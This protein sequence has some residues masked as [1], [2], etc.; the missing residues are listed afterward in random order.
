MFLL[1]K[2]LAVTPVG[3]SDQSPREETWRE[4]DQTAGRHLTDRKACQEA[5]PQE[6]QPAAGAVTSPEATPTA[7]PAHCGSG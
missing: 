2:L 3:K 6:A 4:G 5:V 7:G 1:V